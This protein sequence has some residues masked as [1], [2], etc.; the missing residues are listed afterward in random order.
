[1]LPDMEDGMKMN[2]AARMRNSI[3]ES[4]G[5][6]VKYLVHKQN[7]TPLTA[8]NQK[9]L[10]QKTADE[11]FGVETDENADIRNRLKQIVG[12]AVEHGEVLI[13]Q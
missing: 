7:I 5:R 6:F 4:G 11:M 10:L 3:T 2:T 1:M 13:V 9:R 8:K 12:N